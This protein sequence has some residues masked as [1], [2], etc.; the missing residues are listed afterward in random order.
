VFASRTG[1]G[2][3]ARGDV[4]QA[5]VSTAPRHRLGAAERLRRDIVPRIARSSPAPCS[6]IRTRCAPRAGAAAR[7]YTEGWSSGVMARLPRSTATSAAGHPRLAA[8]AAA[9]SAGDMS[10]TG[11]DHLALA[12]ALRYGSARAV[13]RACS[14]AI[15]STHRRSAQE[16]IHYLS[17]SVRTC[18]HRSHDAR[19]GRFQAVQAIKNDRAATIPI[20]M[21]L[22]GGGEYVSQARALGAVG[23]L[24]KQTRIADVSERWSSCT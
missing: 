22:A 9:S 6:A 4:S 19:H 18:L 17:T 12:T 8:A 1:Q 24:P 5:I 11:W 2:W 7:R 15:S 23:V 20:M 21:Y 13:S 14:S 10:G 16:A 3:S